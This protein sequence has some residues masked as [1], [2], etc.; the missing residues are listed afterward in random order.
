[1]SLS[2]KPACGRQAHDSVIPTK[3]KLYKMKKHFLLLVLFGSIVYPSYAQQENIDQAII[4]RIRTEGLNNSQVMK[5]AFYLTDVSGP[6]LSK[7]PGLKR[8]QDWAV[9]TLKSYGLKN[10]ELEPWGKFGQGW[11]VEKNYVAMTAPYYHAIIASPK[12]W[13]PSTNGVVKSDVVIIDLSKIDTII[14]MEPYKGKLKGKIVIFDSPA[15]LSTTFRADANRYTEEELNSMAAP[16]AAQAGRQGPGISAEQMAQFRKTRALRS[17]VGEFLK[18]EGTGLLLSMSRG[19]HGT[20]FTSNGASYAEDA[21]AV[22][23]ELEMSSEDYLRI[24]RLVKAGIKVELEAEIKTQFFKNDLQGYNVIAEIPGTD[25][26][27]K[28]EVVMLGGH[29]DSWHSATGATDNAAGCAVMMEAVRI[30]TAQNLKPKRT[31]RI[32]LWS[33]EEQGLFGS[34]G[35]V[36]NH[37]GNARTMELKADHEKVS[38]YYNLDNGTGKIRGIYLQGNSAAAPIFQ[39]WLAPFKDLE[40]TTIT[41]RNTGGTDHLAFDAVGIPGFQ[42]IQDG[43]DYNTR[44]HHTNMDT[45]DRLIADDLKQSATIIAALVYNTAQRDAKIPRKELPKAQASN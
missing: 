35:Y 22:L 9:S 7:S 26:D 10:V 8:A 40:A 5:T 3:N 15:T 37:Y 36:A 41:S 24:V 42:F 45:Y 27:L 23:P 32:A 20:L 38:A 43:V 31:I 39:A 13:T 25:K 30:I 29:L 28:N 19:A 18:A 16:Q 33:S 14:K 44:T 11:Q 6:R 12:A 4:Q 34:R 1:M 17:Q 2:Y 21:P